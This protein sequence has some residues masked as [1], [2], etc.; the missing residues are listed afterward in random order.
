MLKELI[1]TGLGASVIIRKKI[2]DEIK[3]LE[4]KGKLNK[5]DAKT[6]LESLET[7][8]KAEE[9]RVKKHFKK[10]IREAIDELDLV[11]KKDLEKFKEELK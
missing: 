10:L 5:K 7:T 2:E 6:F 1:Y 3:T 8:G 11:T 9:K 4:K